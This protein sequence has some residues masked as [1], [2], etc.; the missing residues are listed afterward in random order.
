MNV[1]EGIETHWRTPVISA[2][3]RP[4]DSVTDRQ[5]VPHGLE[6]AT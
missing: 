2:A 3:R 6:G 5:A 4:V 1:L